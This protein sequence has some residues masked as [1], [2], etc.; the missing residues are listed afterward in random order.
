MFTSID[1][2]DITLD[3]GVDFWL[4]FSREIN[5]LFE[6]AGL[7]NRV[8]SMSS[9]RD[10]LDDFDAAAWNLNELDNGVNVVHFSHDLEFT[11]VS[12]MAFGIM[13]K[14]GYR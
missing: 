13:I 2:Q 11:K 4:A 5:I 8:S 3:D 14:S 12:M 10:F 7:E 6:H 1:F 9:A